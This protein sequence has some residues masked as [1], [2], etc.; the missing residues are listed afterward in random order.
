MRFSSPVLPLAALVG[1]AL[2]AAPPLAAQQLSLGSEEMLSASSNWATNQR[3][4]VVFTEDGAKHIAW[5]AADTWESEGVFIVDAAT[6]ASAYGAPN[7]LTIGMPGVRYGIG[8]GLELKVNGVYVLATWEGTDPANRPMWFARST[9][10]AATWEAEVRADDATMEERAY[11][12]GTLLP[13]G[14]VAKVWIYYDD[15]TGDPEHQF[16]VQDEFGVFSAPSNPAA[17]SP[18]VPC[19]CCTADPI[20]LDDGTILVAYRNNEDNKRR[21]YVSRST[22]GGTSFPTSVRVDAGGTFFF[23]CPGSPPSITAEGQDVLVVWGKVGGN[24]LKYYAQSARSTDGGVTFAPQ[25]RMDD[26]DGTT[27]IG[28]P[29]VARRGNLAVA[30]WKGKDTATNQFEIWVGTSTDG[31]TTWGPEQ[32]IT[33]DGLAR[34]LGHPAVAISPNDDVEIVWMDARDFT[35]RVYRVGGTAEDGTAAPDVARADKTA[36][37]APNPFRSSTTIRFSSAVASNGRVSIIDVTG[38]QVAILSGQTEVQWDGRDA[39]G[40]LVPAGVYFARTE[41]GVETVRIV[42]LR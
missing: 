7:Q 26:S 13:D 27:T 33:G 36:F 40:D 8:D 29:F 23:A 42:R 1:L 2:F 39:S 15:L 3:P 17:E 35:D 4:R 41:A 32:M 37:A 20:V 10:Y 18:A 11:T 31:G 19:E 34:D 25:V 24:P 14:R 22:D 9:D 38:R 16:R 28:H 12:T 30:V 21:M 6:A 5:I